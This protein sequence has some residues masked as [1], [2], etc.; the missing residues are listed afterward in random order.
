MSA[1]RDAAK[2]ICLH[3]HCLSGEADKRI[4]ALCASERDAG[5]REA[6]EEVKR[7]WFKNE[8]RWMTVSDEQFNDWLKARLAGGERNVS[9]TREAPFWCEPIVVADLATHTLVPEPRGLCRLL[10]RRVGK[11]GTEI[12]PKTLFCGPRGYIE[13]AAKALN[14]LHAGNA[15]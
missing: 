1:E 13:A 12:S 11:R 10:I 3:A 8:T 6:L 9:G 7:E 5:R 4:D 15:P 2:E 14:N